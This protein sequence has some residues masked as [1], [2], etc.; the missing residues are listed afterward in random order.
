MK[1]KTAKTV[2]IVCTAVEATLFVAAYLSLGSLSRL[3]L[4]AGLAV[5]C[6]NTALSVKYLRCP[7]C[8]SL[9]TR[10]TSIT[11]CPYCG[12]DLNPEAKGGVRK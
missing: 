9:L 3:W 7:H 5:L 2:Y 6:V 12:E 8:G 11:H 10:L 1:L 4:I